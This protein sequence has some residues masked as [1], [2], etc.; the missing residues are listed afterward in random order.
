MAIAAATL[1]ACGG[2][3]NGNANPGSGSG[4]GSP[5]PP[6][7]PVNTTP[8]V[9]DE[10]NTG[11]FGGALLQVVLLA[12]DLTE[13]LRP[14]VSASIPTGST[15]NSCILGGSVRTQVSNDRLQLT[16]TFQDCRVQL[17]IDEA[18]FNGVRRTVY[19]GPAGNNAF[20]ADHTLEDFVVDSAGVRETNNG[21]I[22]YDAGASQNLES[23]DSMTFDLRIDNTAEGGLGVQNV[24]LDIRNSVDFLNSLLGIESATGQ[25]S[26][27]V[28]GRVDL[29]FDASRDAITVAGAGTGLGVIEIRGSG[30]TVTHEPDAAVAA[31]AFLVLSIDDLYEI[32]FFNAS[33]RFGP[34]RASTFVSDLDNILPLRQDPLTFSLRQNFSDRD[35]DLLVLALT[36][37]DVQIRDRN[38]IIE[39]VPVDDPRVDVTV[40]EDEAGIYSVTSA[41][42]GE[43]V[44]YSFDV[45][46]TDPTGLST[47]DAL[48]ISFSIYLDT[49]GDR[50]ADRFDDDD[51]ND[52][53]DDFLDRFPLDE[54]ESADNDRDG[55]GDNAD[56]D[57]DNDGTPDTSDAYP[58]DAKCFLPSDG[59]GS[60]CTLSR[61]DWASDILVDRDGI[62]HI[63]YRFGLPADRLTVFRLDTSTGHFI[64]SITLDPT[65]LG[66]D[67]ATA[68]YFITYVIDHHALYVTYD[69]FG[70]T[71]ID[72]TDPTF[73][74]VQF[75]L[76]EPTSQFLGRASD[77]S[78]YVVT[79][80]QLMQ[81]VTRFSFDAS[82]AQIDSYT[83]QGNSSDLDFTLAANANFCDEG[84]T[85]NV[86]DGT[87]FEYSN[88]GGY[89]CATGGQPLPSPDGTLAINGQ[90][91]ILDQTF[92]VVANV[93]TQ[94][95]PR[96]RFAWAW[97]SDGI[98]LPSNAG[99]EVFD[100]AGQPITVVTPAGPDPEFD[101]T[102][103]HQAGDVVVIA[104]RA[105]GDGIRIQRYVPPSP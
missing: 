11:R 14:G 67:P 59:D 68:Q 88:P 57:D 81:V 9:L 53:V 80:E 18:T 95:R 60:R 40:T 70:M 7:P 15:N 105:V 36:P 21:S 71:K 76:R 100:V 94:E 10:A 93:T 49:D 23:Q 102:T 24:T 86:T 69:D 16:E 47:L 72:L 58:F 35:G 62:A 83:S 73:P 3:G 26:H 98:F 5:P 43:V 2:G 34:L 91:E 87:F 6:P 46:A 75:K 42:D 92:A 44:S 31:T 33:N 104:F 74:E 30:I 82:G 84:V 77:F 65:V 97:S 1:V 56:T 38:G 63:Y 37:T 55:I 85:L 19:S 22:R 20:T 101:N 79:S 45:I 66:L 103:V 8:A 29:G 78:P 17:G 96:G 32:E 41:T 4:G 54:T 90:L 52:G 39:P 99:A 48:P 50:D 64:E 61:L 13:F 12:K 27:D 25:I 28:D 51:D 89:I